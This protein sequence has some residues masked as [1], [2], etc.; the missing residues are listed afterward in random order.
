[1]LHN[2]KDFSINRARDSVFF[3][4]FL[5]SFFRDDI[6]LYQNSPVK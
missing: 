2:C 5:Y 3:W 1:L 6:T 4:I